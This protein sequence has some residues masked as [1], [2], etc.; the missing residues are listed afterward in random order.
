MKH[1]THWIYGEGWQD[2]VGYYEGQQSGPYNGSGGG[3]TNIGGSFDARLWFGVTIYRG[4]VHN[5]DNSSLGYPR[6]QVWHE[7]SINKTGDQNWFDHR[8]GTWVRKF[9]RLSSIKVSPI[10][11]NSLKVLVV[12]CFCIE[13]Y[14]GWGVFLEVSIYMLNLGELSLAGDRGVLQ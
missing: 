9:F 14:G 10:P 5:M 13:F 7:V 12:R 6:S 1:L 4:L 2:S 3:F 11:F 8:R